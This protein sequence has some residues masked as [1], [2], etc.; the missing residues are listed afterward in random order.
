LASC[1]LG[2]VGLAQAP[3]EATTAWR[4][5]L[6]PVPGP[7]LP[8]NFLKH[9][10]EQTVVGLAAVYRAIHDSRL[11]DRDFSRWAVL[12]A[13]C[14]LGRTYIADTLHQLRRWGPQKVS[15]LAI[16][17]QC[18]HAVASTISLALKVHGPCFG[19]GGG[20]GGV[21]QGL[22]AALTI[23]DDSQLP[24]AWLVLTQWFPEPVPDA[25]SASTP[26]CQALAL[27]CVRDAPDWRGFRLRLVRSGS[28][29]R[30][31]AAELSAIEP[32]VAALAQFFSRQGQAGAP[33]A[34][35]C[36]LSWGTSLEVSHEHPRGGLDHRCWDG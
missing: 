30:A 4:Q 24:G 2:A 21:A 23:L 22:L 26:S 17:N 10:D 13:P 35:S 28:S 34:W 8:P 14:F 16:P 1:G 11:G 9:S 25:E 18:L 19:V 33:Q 29:A 36:P 6:G 15:P 20:L 12:A 31:A 5:N 3:L 32:N 27:A 7:P